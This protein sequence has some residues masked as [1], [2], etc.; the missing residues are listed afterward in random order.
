MAVA[1]SNHSGGQW[2]LQVFTRNAAY[3]TFILL[4]PISSPPGRHMAWSAKPAMDPPNITAKLRNMRGRMS[5]KDMAYARIQSLLISQ[6]APSIG[7]EG[8]PER[9]PGQSQVANVLASS[10]VGRKG[11]SPEIQLRAQ[12]VRLGQAC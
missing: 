8:V 4:S 7:G 11:I 12:R 1:K 9:A 5:G 3:V 10:E 6:R 2:L